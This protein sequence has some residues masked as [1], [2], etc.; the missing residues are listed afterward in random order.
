M[1]ERE[2]A[3]KCAHM[4]KRSRGRGREPEADSALNMKPNTGLDPSTP[5][6]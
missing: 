3:C 5:K 1:I 6:S 2:K 4:V